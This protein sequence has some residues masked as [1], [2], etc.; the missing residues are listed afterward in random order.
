MEYYAQVLTNVGKHIQLDKGE[1][2]YFTSLL[3]VCNV[4]KKELL[5]KEGDR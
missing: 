4:R 3:T 2:E 1:A 5:L